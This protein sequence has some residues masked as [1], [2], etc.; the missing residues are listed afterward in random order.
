[1]WLIQLW[2]IQCESYFWNLRLIELG[3]LSWRRG[4]LAGGGPLEEFQINKPIEKV[5]LI[6]KQTW[7]FRRSTTWN[8][9]DDP[10]PDKTWI[11]WPAHWICVGWIWVVWICVGWSCCVDWPCG[12]LG[13]IG[14][15]TRLIFGIAFDGARIIN[16]FTKNIL[17]PI[18]GILK[19]SGSVICGQKSIV[20]FVV[21]MTSYIDENF[22]LYDYLRLLE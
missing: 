10:D 7:V 19:T 22:L 12:W 6:W 9:V 3:P 17:N 2:V 4:C 1:M 13:L 11:F 14:E 8:P 20:T 16:E 5:R 21:L 15:L 18:W